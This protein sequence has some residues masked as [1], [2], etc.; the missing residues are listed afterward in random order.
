[1]TDRFVFFILFDFIYSYMS[2]LQSTIFYYFC[3][4]LFYSKII[5]KIN[6]NNFAWMWLVYLVCGSERENND[7]ADILLNFNR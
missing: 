4:R 6:K 5:L 1:M 7:V 2:N 3:N